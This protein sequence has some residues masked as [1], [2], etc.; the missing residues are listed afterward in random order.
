MVKSKKIKSA[1]PI[2]V[3]AFVWTLFGLILPLYKL[4]YILLC[5]GVSIAAYLVA[6]RFFPGRE[7]ELAYEPDSGD[8]QLNGQIRE[9]IAQLQEIRAANEAISA[10]EVSAH[11]DRMEK[12]GGQIF[13]ALE[14]KPEKA[15]QVRRFMNYY[16][17]TTVK[18]LGLYRQF[19]E[20]GAAGENMRKSMV[21]IERSMEMIAAAF[22]KQLD[23]L[24]DAEALD[25]SADIE[26]LE[27]ML[28]QG[29][30]LRAGA[31]D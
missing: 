16:L 18:L 24:Y 2:Y 19:S 27:T 15:G 21:S 22:E 6:S 10:P 25:I 11:L 5:V 17:P 13:R 30:S 1:I 23:H 14:Q 8:A 9:G 4:S 28:A 31:P 29:P 26:V 3:S 20:S 7:V 12:A